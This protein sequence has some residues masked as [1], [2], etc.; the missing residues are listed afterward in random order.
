MSKTKL[1]AAISG[2]DAEQMRALIL[3]VYD[4]RRE[5]K[6]YLDFFADPDVGGMLRKYKNAL[7]KECGRVSRG[8]ARPRMSKVRKHIKDFASFNPGDEYV[9]EIMVTAM[10][11]LCH[12]GSDTWVPEQTQ[13]SIAKL[14]ESTILFILTH[15]VQ[16]Q[17]LPRIDTAIKDMKSSVFYRNQFK[18]LLRETLEDTLDS[19][20]IE[21]RSDD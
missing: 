9:A 8:R 11:L 13:R 7:V 21:V 2:L 15:G 17:M 18:R 6:E 4:A 16:Q 14:L 5:A 10:E 20:G 12:A 1:K 19:Y 3:D